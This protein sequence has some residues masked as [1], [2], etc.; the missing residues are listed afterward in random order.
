MPRDSEAGV[1][2]ARIPRTPV[3][4]AAIVAITLVTLGGVLLPALWHELFLR[5]GRSPGRMALAALTVAVLLALYGRLLWLI[6]MRRTSRRHWLGLVAVAVLSCLPPSGFG[7]QW[8]TSLVIP[9]GL[10]PL[11]LPLRPAVVVT[12]ASTIGITVY[13]LL[14]GLPSLTLVYEFFWFPLAAFSG[15]VS[16]W[17]FH[18]VQE[19]REARAELAKAAVGEERQRFARDL[20]DV[21]GHSLQALALRAE[22]AE[23]Y[24]DRD[25]GRVRKELAE[26]QRV[27][28][29]SVQDVREVVRGHRAVSLRSELEGM[30]A[31]LRAAGIA[32]APPEIPPDLPAHVAEPLGWVAREAVT[33]VL[34]HSDAAWCRMA[35]RVEPGSV[36]LEITNDGA[37]SR[38]TRTEG[39]GLPGL[40]ERITAVGGT[41]HAG[42]DGAGSFRVVA[43]VPAGAEG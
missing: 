35:V 34:R 32:C 19:L 26:I 22:V 7:P 37:R 42:P 17:M 23:R 16:I 18:V 6:L 21:L 1:V 8:A 9:A 10:I 29:A 36:H 31:V 12:A 33:N 27:A 5:P 4:A 2:R 3:I 20:H 28:R 14:L 15:Y 38:S 13:G 11:L 43:T 41:F 40:A 39:T 30:S 24:L 25:R